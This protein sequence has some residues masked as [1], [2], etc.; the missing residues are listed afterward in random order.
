ME[1]E[2]HSLVIGAMSGT[3]LDGL[4]IALCSFSRE[5]KLQFK[6][7]S[8]KTF[9]FSEKLKND[10]ESCRTLSGYELSQ[11]D[12]KLGSFIAKCINFLLE[13]EKINKEEIEAIGSHGHTVF[14]Q[15]EAGI[16]LQIG[17]GSV[18]HSNTQIPVVCDFRKMDV[19]LG[20]QGAPLVPIG[21][22]LLFGKYDA[23]INL[24]GISNISFESLK[25]RMAF[26]M[27]PFNLGFNYIAQKIN[28]AYDEDGKITSQG[29]VI[30]AFKNELDQL[31]YYQK[32]APKSLGIEW[33]ERNIFPLIDQF[34]NSSSI[35][36]LLFTYCKHV[37]EQMAKCIK[38]HHLKSVFMTGGG[39]YHKTFVQQLRDLLPNSQITIPKKEIIEYK[40]ALIFA[41]LAYLKKNKQINVYSSVTGSSKD[42]SS[43]IE[44]SS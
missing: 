21:D 31:E 19:A 5:G 33:L 13:S 2:N 40:E 36:D 35:E 4:D 3:S 14:H 25:G 1:N 42:H 9:P 39:V 7:L 16:T 18:I 24:G 6:I 26:D 29:K 27:T 12:I 37:S 23:C 11:L 8:A 20:G 41:L 22:R 32:E 34:G 15:P 44:F 43:G 30:E 28:L 10:L 38:T 17:S